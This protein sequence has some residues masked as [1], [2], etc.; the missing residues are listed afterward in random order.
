MTNLDLGVFFKINHEQIFELIFYTALDDFLRVSEALKF[1]N[2]WFYMTTKI[3][4]CWLYIK[5]QNY[6]CSKHQY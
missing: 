2:S 3:N 5:N 1:V 4:Y 6:T